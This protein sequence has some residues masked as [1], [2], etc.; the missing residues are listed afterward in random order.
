MEFTRV[1]VVS[2]AGGAS[3]LFCSPPRA[4]S[5]HQDREL[6]SAHPSPSS[7]PLVLWLP[8]TSGRLIPLEAHTGQRWVVIRNISV[9]YPSILA[10][11]MFSDTNEIHV[12]KLP[13]QPDKTVAV[14]GTESLSTPPRA[15]VLPHQKERI[16]GDRA[17]LSSGRLIG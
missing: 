7:L 17:G 15:P 3:G 6:E 12:V 4:K 14:V 10:P 11:G 16:S 13:R 2:R 1:P 5:L 8:H 9:F